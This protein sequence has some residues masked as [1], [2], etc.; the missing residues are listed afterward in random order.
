[1]GGTASSSDA[2]KAN[3]RLPD[4]GT[5]KIFPYYN[6]GLKLGVLPCLDASLAWLFSC[7]GAAGSR[8]DTSAMGAAAI[9]TRLNIYPKP[10]Q[11]AA[12][13]L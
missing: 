11:V 1:M 2:A 10:W 3:E 13:T 4:K 8:N 5:V 12:D 9:V 7:A 6:V